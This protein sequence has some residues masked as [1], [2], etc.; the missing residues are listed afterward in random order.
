MLTGT[1][2]PS[3]S[4]GYNYGVKLRIT[5]TG[6]SPASSAASLA[7]RHVPARQRPLSHPGTQRPLSGPMGDRGTL[8]NQQGRDRALP[9]KVRARR[10]PGTLRGV[11]AGHPRAPVRQPLRQ[12]PQQRRQRG[13]AGHAHQLNYGVKLRITPTGLSPA[14]SAAS[15]AARHVPA[16]QRP[17]SHPGTQ[18]PLSGP[19][20]DRGTLQNQQG[21]E[22]R[23]C[24]D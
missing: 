1:R 11:H 19:M 9:C 23:G 22:G 18:R 21:D 3:L 24:V 8:Q 5:P 13:P 14:S 17:L 16:R 15:L 4:A 20:G 10:P 2:S 12:R 6:L 7:A